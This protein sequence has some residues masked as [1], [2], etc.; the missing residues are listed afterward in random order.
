MIATGS[1]ARLMIG[2]KENLAGISS[3]NTQ[4]LRRD[5]ATA[6]RHELV[7]DLGALSQTCVAGLLDS[8]DVH[9]HVSS[10]AVRLNEAVALVGLNHFTFPIAISDFPNEALKY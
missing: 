2:C 4:I 3:A 6:A 10:A 7:A 8:E 1:L 5:L 9:K